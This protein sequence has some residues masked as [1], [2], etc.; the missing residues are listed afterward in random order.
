MKSWQSCLLGKVVGGVVRDENATTLVLFDILFFLSLYGVFSSE[1]PGVV[2]V[3]FA[4]S[5]SHPPPVTIT[6]PAASKRKS[7]GES[8]SGFS[9]FCFRERRVTPISSFMLRRVA[10]IA[11]TPVVLIHASA[12][13]RVKVAEGPLAQHIA[14]Y[15]SNGEDLTDAVRNEYWSWHRELLPHRLDQFYREWAVLRQGGRV[16]LATLSI[17]DVVYVLR[18]WVL[19]L[20]LLFM[21]GVMLGRRSIYP[22]I[23]PTSPFNQQLRYENPNYKYASIETI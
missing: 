17:K 3:V 2:E 8:G 7:V 9:P 12:V 20:V 18:F 11:T 15:K 13:R 6:Q 14:A 22:W 1:T 5:R 4:F 16:S 21:I 23:A 10:S 19:R